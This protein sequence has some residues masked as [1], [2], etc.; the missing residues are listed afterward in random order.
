[1]CNICNLYE[2]TQSCDESK[3]ECKWLGS[4][5]GSGIGIPRSRRHRF[6]HRNYNYNYYMDN[7][8]DDDRASDRSHHSMGVC[9]DHRDVTLALP[10]I[11]MRG[12]SHD[13]STLRNGGF[14]RLFGDRCYARDNDSNIIHVR[15]A[16]LF[17]CLFFLSFSSN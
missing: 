4:I 16:P 7:N 6:R 9:V 8:N 3:Y 17:F 15:P 13:Q 14:V 5:T 1:V 2:S 10:T 11:F 12:I